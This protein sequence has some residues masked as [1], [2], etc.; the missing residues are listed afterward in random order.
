MIDTS[1]RRNLY[2]VRPPIGFSL[3]EVMVA[4]TIG[5]IIVLAVTQIFTNSHA[6]YQATDGLSRIQENG[7]F[8]M[9]FLTR[10][11]RMAGYWGC[12]NRSAKVYNDLNSTRDTADANNVIDFRYNFRVGIEGFEANGTAPGNTYTIASYTPS[13]STTLNAWTPT[14]DASLT[15]KAI[16]GS[17]VLV[18]R[19]FGDETVPL[20][21]NT[22]GQYQSG[23]DLYMPK[24][25]MSDSLAVGDI[26]AVADCDKASLFQ[27]SAIALNGA[28]YTVSHATGGT[29]PGNQCGS[30]ANGNTCTA[31]ADQ[32]YGQGTDAYRATTTVFY[33]GKRANG[34]SPGLHRL[35]LNGGALVEEELVEDVESMQILYGIDTDTP[36]GTAPDGSANKFV[37]AGNVADWS[38]VISVRLSILVRSPDAT[39]TSP[40]LTIYP[41]LDSADG[42]PVNIDPPDDR[43]RRRVFNTTVQLRN[44]IPG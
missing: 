40:D 42:T 12:V 15:N 43:R 32:T 9:E 24:T 20:A 38:K 29:S 1:P 28:K 23:A 6:T 35:V 5:L 3:V 33:I 19:A 41:L 10:E 25:D 21:T 4:M 11:I 14:L 22:S 44:R 8:A 26:V 16:K 18:I 37:T 2:L 27:I 17:D 34:D 36:A 39:E 31:T 13:P 7:R 30:W